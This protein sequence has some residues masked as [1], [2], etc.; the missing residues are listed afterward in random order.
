M[1]YTAKLDRAS[2]NSMLKFILISGCGMGN[3]AHIIRARARARVGAIM[4]IIRDDVSGCVG[5]LV[6]SLIASAIGCNRP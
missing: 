3:G 4:N 1:A 5:S 6:N 2:M